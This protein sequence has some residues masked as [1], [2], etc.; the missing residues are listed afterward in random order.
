MIGILFALL[1]AFLWATNDILNKKSLLMGYNENFVLWI[2]FPVGAFLLLPVGLIFWDF[3]PT[4]LWT[5]FVW[6]PLEVFAS[7]LFIKGIK[8]A[9]LSV[10]MPFFAFMPLFSAFFGFVFLGERL[11]LSGFA[12]ILLILAGSFALSGGSLITFLRVN[13]G[14]FYMLVSAFLFGCSVAIGKFVIVESNPYFFAWFYCAV[15]SVGLLPIV[16]FGE[17]LRRK[18]YTN[19]FNLPMGVLFCLGMLAYTLALENTFT[20]YV[21]SIERLAI[22]L[23]VIYGRIFFGEEIRRSLWSSFVMVLGAVLLTL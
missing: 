23:D 19:P 20:S 4:V 3:N 5:T 17:V 21:A 8:Y 10:G 6:L 13:R 7:V 18:N 15:M 2:R 9:P 1:S 22:I 12:G 16:G 11:G 14:S